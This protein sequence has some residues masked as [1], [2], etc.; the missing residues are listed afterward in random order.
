M[1]RLYHNSSISSQTVS[2]L[3]FIDPMIT[4]PKIQLQIAPRLLSLGLVELCQHICRKKL[5]C[6]KLFEETNGE[7][8]V[9][10]TAVSACL[11]CV[12]NL[13]DISVDACHRIIDIGL[14]EDIFC[15]LNLDSIDPS[16]VK[17]CYVRSHFADSAMSVAYNVI[18]VSQQFLFSFFR[19]SKT[20]QLM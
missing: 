19:L 16:K 3:T 2:D 10:T 8:S 6:E 12:V 13:T 4:D 5:F 9:G 7:L 17:L 15:F 18:Q 14:H 1:Q 20:M 11:G